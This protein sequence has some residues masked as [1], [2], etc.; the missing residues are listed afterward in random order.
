M[1]TEEWNRKGYTMVYNVSEA[2]IDFEPTDDLVKVS[3]L[4]RY[5]LNEGYR[6]FQ[7]GA[8]YARSMKPCFYYVVAVNP[9]AAVNKF[10]TVTPWLSK[11]RSVKPMNKEETEQILNNPA[12]YILW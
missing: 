8:S 2:G 4:A 6:V 12:R 10:L 7:V 3:V 5:N 11:I 9:A 1:K